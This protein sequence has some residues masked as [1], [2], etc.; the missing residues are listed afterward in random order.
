MMI[1]SNDKEQREMHAIPGVSCFY[2]S[3][4]TY[5]RAFHSTK[6]I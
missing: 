4:K 5:R 6:A 2:V 1:Y 3:F